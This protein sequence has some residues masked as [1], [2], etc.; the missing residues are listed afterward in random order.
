MLILDLFPVTSRR[1]DGYMGITPVRLC[2]EVRAPQ[3]LFVYLKQALQRPWASFGAPSPLDQEVEQLVGR[4]LPAGGDTSGINRRPNQCFLR[5][6][7]SVVSEVPSQ[8][9]HQRPPAARGVREEKERHTELSEALWLL[10][11]WYIQT[12]CTPQRKPKQT[13]N[14][15]TA[16]HLD[17]WLG[18]VYIPFSAG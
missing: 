18:R 10:Q 5:G 2:A 11:Y 9:G 3:L 12:K 1:L 16:N 7:A 15:Q 6:G 8:L 4:R 14:H 17:L 13:A